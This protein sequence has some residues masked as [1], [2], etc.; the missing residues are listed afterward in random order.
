MRVLLLSPDRAVRA[1]SLGVNIVRPRIM[2]PT[3]TTTI[4]QPKPRFPPET[5][6]KK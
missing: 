2:P 5:T 6:S 3:I 1:A 4:H